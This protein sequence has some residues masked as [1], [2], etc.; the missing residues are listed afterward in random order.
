MVASNPKQL[1]DFLT[2][3]RSAIEMALPKHLNPDRMMRLAL[4]CFSTQPALRDC[5]PQSILASVVV[6]SQIGLEPG[7]AGQGYL[8]PYKGKCTFVPGWQGLVGLLNNTGRA[9]AWTGSVFEGDVWEFALGSQPRCNHVPGPNFGDVDKLIWVYACGKVN[10]SEQPV[11]EAWPVSRVKKHRDRY[12]KVGNAHYS[13]TNFEMYARKVVLLQVLKYMP[14]SIELNNAIVA[15]DAAEVGKAVYADNGVIIEAETGDIETAPTPKP[16]SSAPAPVNVFPMKPV[17]T[18]TAA[19]SAQR[20]VPQVAPDENPPE[21]QA[22]AAVA[23]PPASEPQA[24]NPVTVPPGEP[25]PPEVTRE[26]MQATPTPEQAP[27]GQEGDGTAPEPS[28]ATVVDPKDANEATAFITTFATRDGV[29]EDQIMAYLRS[30]K[31]PLA[32]AGQKLSDMSSMKLIAIAKGWNVPA[33]NGKTIC[34][35]V[36]ELAGVA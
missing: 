5:S 25:M 22:P 21:S 9:T 16:S 26:S 30:T 3:S 35:S 33:A 12:N 19:P 32:K 8:I 7:V 28:P 17:A 4:T 23:T 27:K 13:F 14:R 1:L 6:A 29:T 10:G 31:P 18:T 36:K 2:R 11:V 15:V 24:A 34:A 20:R